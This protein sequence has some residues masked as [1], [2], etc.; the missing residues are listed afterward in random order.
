MAR[1]LSL[2]GE[3]EVSTSGGIVTVSYRARNAGD[4]ETGGFADRAFISDG[5][6]A[7]NDAGNYTYDTANILHSVAP[8]ESYDGKIE[9]ARAAPAGTY[10]VTL[11]LD[12]EGTTN[13]VWSGQVTVAP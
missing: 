7:T 13:R 3:P 1:E 10:T 8:G 6:G 9:Q 5:V 12:S 4:L 2:E 11:I